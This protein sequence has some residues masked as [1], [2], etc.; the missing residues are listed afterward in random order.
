VHCISFERWFL[1]FALNDTMLDHSYYKSIYWFT[2]VIVHKW[3]ILKI[4]RDYDDFIMWPI[5][6]PSCENGGL[7]VECV[8]WS[9]VPEKPKELPAPHCKPRQKCKRLKIVWFATYRLP[10]TI[11]SWKKWIGS[12]LFFYIDLHIFIFFFFYWNSCILH[13]YDVYTTASYFQ[14]WG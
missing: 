5:L 13:T 8:T 1:Q 7:H 3:L 10:F 11:N 4:R 14:C 2:L 12:S 9:A 6:S